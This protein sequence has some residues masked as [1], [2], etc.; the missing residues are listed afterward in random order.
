VMT[1]RIDTLLA[2]RHALVAGCEHLAGV[3]RS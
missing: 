2:A 3:P 1:A